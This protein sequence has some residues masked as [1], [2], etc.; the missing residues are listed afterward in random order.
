MAVAPP[1][2]DA[3]ELTT[4][5]PIWTVARKRSGSFLRLATAAAD[6]T[7]FSR[8][9]SMRLLRVVMIAISDAAKKPLARINIK[10]N[11]TSNQIFSASIDPRLL[12]L[13]GQRTGESGGEVVQFLTNS[14]D[15]ER[16]ENGYRR[17]G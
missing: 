9:A 4:V 10:I 12:F 8:R 13:S 6:L 2:A 14:W 11:N 5:T 7:P 1:R 15:A 17:T 3:S 16:H